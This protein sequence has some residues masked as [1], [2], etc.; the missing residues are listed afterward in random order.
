MFFFVIFLSSTVDSR[1]LWTVVL[2]Q[3]PDDFRFQIGPGDS[4]TAHSSRSLEATEVI[5]FAHSAGP[6]LLGCMMQGGF[7][8]RGVLC[9][10]VHVFHIFRDLS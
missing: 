8:V 3:V 10:T 1:G 4:D 9:L 7:R 6:R 5:R 2:G